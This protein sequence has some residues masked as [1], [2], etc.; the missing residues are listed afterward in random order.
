MTGDFLTKL[1][2]GSIF[3]NFRDLVMGVVPQ[4]DPN[5]GNRTTERKRKLRKVIIIKRRSGQR[6][7]YHKR[8][9]ECVANQRTDSDQNRIRIKTGKTGF[10]SQIYLSQR[11]IQRYME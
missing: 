1:N 6:D 5:K 3:N 10:E 9:Q 2:Q 8:P 11:S 7:K 4:T